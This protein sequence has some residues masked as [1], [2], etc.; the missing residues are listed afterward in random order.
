LGLD[1]IRAGFDNR[2]AKAKP[3]SALLVDPK[4]N[5]CSEKKIGAGAAGH[6]HASRS[7]GI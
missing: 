4:E 6:G 3:L 7:A 5:W 2:G 1:R